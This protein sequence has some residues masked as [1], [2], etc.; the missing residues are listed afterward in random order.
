MVNINGQ[1]HLNGELVDGLTSY[2]VVTG[3][4]EDLPLYMNTPYAPIAKARLKYA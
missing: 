4:L 3:P 1:Y 2:K